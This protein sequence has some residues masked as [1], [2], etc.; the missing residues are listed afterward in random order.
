MEKQERTYQELFAELQTYERAGVHMEIDG[1]P[2]SPMQIVSAHMVRE[3]C[4]Y[5]RDYIVRD[6]GVV[7]EINFY[8]VNSN[9]STKAPR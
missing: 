5:M 2:A 6:D 3:E 1:V 8:H 9:E 4:G 7:K